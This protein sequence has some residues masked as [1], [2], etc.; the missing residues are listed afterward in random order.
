MAAIANHTRLIGRRLT[1]AL[2]ANWCTPDERSR[3][4]DAWPPPGVAA[5]VGLLTASLASPDAL[6][7]PHTDLKLAVRWPTR[8][9]IA[10]PLSNQYLTVMET[11]THGRRSHNF[12]LL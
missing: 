2:T 10:L 1:A 5:V 3:P 9:D 4:V 6:Q 7:R 12:R 11:T 8:F